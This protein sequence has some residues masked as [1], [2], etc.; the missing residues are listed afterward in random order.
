MAPTSADTSSKLYAAL[1][2]QVS[3]A[4]GCDTV[5]TIRRLPSPNFPG[6]ELLEGVCELEHGDT[7]WALVGVDSASTLYLLD[8]PSAFRFLR[9]VHPGE[10]DST[11]VVP[12]ALMAIRMMGYADYGATV[13]R[14]PS[15]LRSSLLVRL[16]VQ[17]GLLPLT[18][19]REVGRWSYMVDLLLQY[20]DEITAIGVVVNKRNGF[21]S[22]VEEID[23]AVDSLLGQPE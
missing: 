18:R 23:W 14:E 10:I 20:P 9:R 17:A 22:V 6:V 19:V 13:I 12:Y 3:D 11:A 5:G 16:K 7:A 8:S 4:G 15:E 2:S 21:V 1:L